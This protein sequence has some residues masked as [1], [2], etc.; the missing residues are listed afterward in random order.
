VKFEDLLADSEGA[1]RAVL[2]RFG[3]APL[4]WRD[5]HHWQERQAADAEWF[6]LEESGHARARPHWH[7]PR[8]YYLQV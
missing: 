1:L 3:V 4:P 8:D 2:A 5:A 6:D 7:N